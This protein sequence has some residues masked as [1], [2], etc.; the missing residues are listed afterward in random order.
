MKKIIFI[1]LVLA[2]AGSAQAQ[3]INEDPWFVAFF[4]SGWF[5][6]LLM[7]AVFAW[8]GS[9]ILPGYPGIAGGAIVG[10]ISMFV[11]QTVAEGLILLSLFAVLFLIAAVKKNKGG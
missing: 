7:T 3:G 1:L 5:L 10:L 9:L 4:T 8:F 6:L 2:L 11:M